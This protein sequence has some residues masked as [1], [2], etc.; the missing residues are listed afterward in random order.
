MRSAF[1]IDFSVG[2]EK[3]VKLWRYPQDH[4][5]KVERL[6]EIADEAHVYQSSISSIRAYKIL[7]MVEGEDKDDEIDANQINQI[8][9]EIET[10]KQRRK[11]KPPSLTIMQ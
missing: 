10:E 5:R 1:A 2:Y 8:N 3:S 9:Q 4:V 11:L 6:R 7:S